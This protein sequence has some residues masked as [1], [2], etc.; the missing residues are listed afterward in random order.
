M[1]IVFFGEDSFSN[2]VLQS[3]I[4][5][6]HKILCVVCPKYENMEHIRLQQTSINNGIPFLREFDVN[7][8]QVE[9]HL[10]GFNPEIFVSA[11]FK[12]LLKE[13]L[14]KIPKFGGINLHP[15]LLP[16]YRGMSPQHW[17][18][19]NGERQTGVTVHFINTEADKGDIIL[20]KELEIEDHW[21]VTDLQ[22][23]LLEIYKT[24]V[25][26]AVRIVQLG[27]GKYIRQDHLE[28]TYYGPLKN[29]DCQIDI[30]GS[31]LN[32]YNLIRAVSKPYRG[33]QIDNYI[34]WRANI[35]DEKTVTLIDNSSV[36]KGVHFTGNGNFIKFD[37]GILLINKYE[38]KAD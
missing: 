9:N 32:A 1:N 23:R 5:D 20:Q 13:N 2:V 24:I 27:D 30:N 11:H 36:K 22:K 16:F 31:L 8:K 4:D 12:K 37:D 15:S 14:I 17:P 34:I 18:I 10:K 38:I 19:I 33:A 7:S 6:G 35:A 26:D 21:Y 29:K 25:R 28:G 3:L